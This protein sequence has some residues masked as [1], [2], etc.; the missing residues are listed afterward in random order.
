MSFLCSRPF[1]AFQFCMEKTQITTSWFATTSKMVC[2]PALAQLSGHT[3]YFTN[4]VPVPLAI[5]FLEPGARIPTPVT[6]T[7]W[8]P[9]LG[10]LRLALHV[11]SPVIIYISLN[12]TSSKRKFVELF[13]QK[14]VFPWVFCLFL[15]RPLRCLEQDFTVLDAQEIYLMSVS[16]LFLEIQRKVIYRLII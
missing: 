5:A 11:A 12:A 14:S 10:A 2:D 13:I 1:C 9:H 8:L 3:T 16:S 7:C 6:S 15:E 4:H